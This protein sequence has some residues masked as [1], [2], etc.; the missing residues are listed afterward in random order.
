MKIQ[1]ILLYSRVLRLIFTETK[2]PT[3]TLLALMFGSP[4]YNISLKS[5]R[6]LASG[7]KY[8]LIDMLMQSY[9]RRKNQSPIFYWIMGK[10][11]YKITGFNSAATIF[12]SFIN[13]D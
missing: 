13:E 12:S 3:S 8:S 7:E 4:P 6:L 11:K 1:K 5:G 2:S 9:L 10:K